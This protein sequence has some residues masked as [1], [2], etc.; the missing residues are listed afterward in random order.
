MVEVLTDILQQPWGIDFLPDGRMIVTEKPGR[1]RIVTRGGKVS[2]P[3]KNP[4]KRA[5][6]GQGGLLDVTIHPDF[7]KTRL[8]YFSYAEQG[9]DG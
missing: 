2:P 1:I 7:A 4:P 3:S 6:Y 5:Y 8:L 9:P